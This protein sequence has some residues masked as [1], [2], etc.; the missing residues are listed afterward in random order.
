[1][2]ISII[3]PA[4]PLR[5]GIA[6]HVFWLR[7]ELTARAHTVQVVSFRKLYPRI[8]FP[9]TSELD[10]SHL[11]LDAGAAPILGR[12]ADPHPVEPGYMVA[13]V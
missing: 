9:G 8:F 6:H 4:Y 12:G 5:G 3:G 10:T 2:R 13:R 11:K 1:M 7:R